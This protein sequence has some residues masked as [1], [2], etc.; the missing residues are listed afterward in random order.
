MAIVGVRA[1]KEKSRNGAKVIVLARRGGNAR[2]ESFYG[3]GR[4]TRPR[5]ALVIERFAPFEAIFK[6]AECTSRLGHS[7]VL[8]YSRSWRRLWRRMYVAICHECDARVE[9]SE[10][11]A[12]AKLAL[13]GTITP[14]ES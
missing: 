13:Y 7:W 8:V 4:F 11:E 9:I 14:L 2:W 3:K 1:V 12:D 6:P 10:S 5:P